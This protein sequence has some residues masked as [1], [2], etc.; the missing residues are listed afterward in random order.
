[1][2]RFKNLKWDR[3][4]IPASLQEILLEFGKF[5]YSPSLAWPIGWSSSPN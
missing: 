1:M 4:R 5:F 3:T 2:C